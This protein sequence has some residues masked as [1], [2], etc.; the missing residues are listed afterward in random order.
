MAKYIDGFVFPIPKS[1]VEAYRKVAEQVAAIWKEHGALSYREWVQDDI[2]LAGTRSFQEAV[3][4]QAGEVIVFGWVEFPSKQICE[5]AHKAVAA[6][7][8]MAEI[9]APLVDSEAPIFAANRMVY[10]RFNKLIT[11]G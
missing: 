4:V 2:H 10:G 1:Q 3:V 9:V 5:E 8:R 11:V 6:D 7:A